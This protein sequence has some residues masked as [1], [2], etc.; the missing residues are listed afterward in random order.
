MNSTF[1]KCVWIFKRGQV[2]AEIL[3]IADTNAQ[4]QGNDSGHLD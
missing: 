1:Q 3:E 4:W 2:Q